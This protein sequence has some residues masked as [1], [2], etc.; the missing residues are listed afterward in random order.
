MPWTDLVV[1]GQLK[2]TDEL[3]EIFAAQGV[4]LQRPIIASCGSGVTA[5]IVMLALA[6]LEAS[7]VKLYDGSWSEWGA[8]DDLPI[9]PAL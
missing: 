5:A 6:T 2:T 3:R 1:K 7:D 8:R 4:D 9:E